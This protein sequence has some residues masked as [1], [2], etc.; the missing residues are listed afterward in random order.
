VRVDRHAADR[1]AHAFPDRFSAAVGMVGV[2]V[3]HLPI[4]ERG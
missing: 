4:L 2:V 3:G 1:I